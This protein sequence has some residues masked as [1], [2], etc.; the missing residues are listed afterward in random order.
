MDT[1]TGPGVV[2]TPD[3]LDARMALPHVYS[4]LIIPGGAVPLKFNL[5][6]NRDLAGGQLATTRRRFFAETGK[7]R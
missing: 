3:S 4:I 2:A 1:S 6:E 5:R 7:I